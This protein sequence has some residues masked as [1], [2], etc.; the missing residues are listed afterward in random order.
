MFQWEED[1][2]Q[3]KKY[4]YKI[5]KLGRWKV[6]EVDWDVSNS[7]DEPNPYILHCSLPGIKSSLGKFKTVEDAMAKGNNVIKYWLDK[8]ELEQK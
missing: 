2:A 7:R 4:S 1:Q 8:A 5:G 6:L 3:Y